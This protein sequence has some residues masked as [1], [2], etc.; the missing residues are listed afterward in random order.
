MQ[1]N[2]ETNGIN[3]APFEGL[4]SETP[5][6]MNAWHSLP[7]SSAS[8]VTKYASEAYS[9]AFTL[10]NGTAAGFALVGLALAIFLFAKARPIEKSKN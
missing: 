7:I 10:V 3:P 8:H 4:V 6:S 2:P 9:D 5:A 1:S